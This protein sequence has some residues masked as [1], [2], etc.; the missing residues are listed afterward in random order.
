MITSAYACSPSKHRAG[1]HRSRATLSNVNALGRSAALVVLGS[2][3]FAIGLLVYLTDRDPS[4]AALIPTVAWLS[5][6]N[7]FGLVGGWLPSF[8]H[9][10]AFSLFTAAALP[11]RAAPRYGACIAWFAIN[12]AFEI[13]QLPV[14]SARLAEALHGVLSALPFS[15]LLA[16]Y[17]VQGTFDFGDIVAALLSA[18]AAGVVLRLTHSLGRESHAT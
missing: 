8:A 4:K 3:V 9:T 2:I 17:F 10:F 5:G 18:L 11:E 12:L 13:G 1:R 15:R 6:S 14:V 16:N 7:V